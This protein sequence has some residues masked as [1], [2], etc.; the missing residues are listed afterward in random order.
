[1]DRVD[2]AELQAPRTLQ[3]GFIRNFMLVIGPISS[4]FDFLTFYVMLGVLHADEALF[5]TG[6]FVESLCTQV[7]VIFVIRTRGN[8]LRSR[9]HRILAATSLGIVAVGAL[10][11]F[12]PLGARFGFVPLPLR[13]YGILAAMVVTYLALVEGVKQVFYRRL[14]R[15]G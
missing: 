7:L 2:P 10:L 3:P 6:W 15:S 12:T 5:Q 1:L 8:P 4:I 14:V 11:P 9:P 13:Y